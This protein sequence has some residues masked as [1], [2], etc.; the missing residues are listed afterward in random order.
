MLCISRGKTKQWG[1]SSV[2]RLTFASLRKSGPYLTEF[3]IVNQLGYCGVLTADRTIWI[4]GHF[5]LSERRIQ[6]IKNQKFAGQ[7][8]SCAQ[9]KLEHLIGLNCADDTSHCAPT[10]MVVENGT[11]K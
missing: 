7:K 4:F 3:F 10:A 1:S 5:H 6:G 2:I 9:N 11:L 8:A